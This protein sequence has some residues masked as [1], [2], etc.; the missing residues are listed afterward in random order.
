MNK[1]H[2]LVLL[3]AASAALL[4]R[5][6]NLGLRPM[7]ND[8]GVNAVKFGA[9]LDRG[10]YRYDPHEYH[11]PALHYATL[12]ITRVAGFANSSALTDSALRLTPLVFGVGLIL[13]LPLMRDGFGSKS[14][15][16]AGLF[17]AVS[18]AF[19][20]YS[21]YFIHEMLLVFFTASAIASGWRYWRSRHVAWALLCGASIGL[22]HAS[23]ETFVFALAAGVGAMISNQAWNRW[24]DAS[25]QPFRAP[26]LNYWHVVFGALAWALPA[27][28]L[29]SSFG[30][31]WAGLID[32]F[33]TYLPWLN[34]AGGASPHIHPWSFYLERLLFFRTDAGPIWSEASIAVLAII[35]A[36]AGF[37]RK[38]LESDC[39]ASFLRFVALFTLLLAGIYT[40]IPYKTPW[41]FLGFWHGA[42]LLAGVGMMVLVHSVKNQFARVAAIGVLVV[43]S[44]QLAWQGWAATSRYAADRRNPYVYAQTSPDVFRLIDKVISVTSAASDPRQTHINVIGADGDYWPLPWYLRGF[45]R[46]GWWDNLPADPYAP[47]MIVSASLQAGLDAQRTHLMI[48]YF[49]LRPGVFMEMYVELELWKAFLAQNPPTTPPG[50]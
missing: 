2:A 24:A 3:F 7:H 35:G 14:V 45:T 20:F 6:P 47:I 9:L 33:K 48:G 31:N 16:C 5:G 49:E 50:D 36:S 8:E 39:N 29:F 19:I 12:A 25:K 28:L 17:T 21:E 38:R 46:V 30:S 11:G 42:I 10:E 27:M 1:W 43:I 15:L 26:K 41:C 4:L 44:A 32:A 40:V 34:R 23:K 13:L 37:A 22:M 18:P